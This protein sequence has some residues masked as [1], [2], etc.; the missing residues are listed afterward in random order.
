MA[1]GILYIEE[2]HR[3]HGI[4]RAHVLCQSCFDELPA[5]MQVSGKDAHGYETIVRPWT[6]QQT[7][8]TDCTMDVTPDQ[9]EAR[10]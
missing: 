4:Q 7:D 6:G 2:R 10:S 3:V 5:D 8:C 1:H 9:A